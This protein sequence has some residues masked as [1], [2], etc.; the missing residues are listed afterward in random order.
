MKTLEQKKRA[1]FEKLRGKY[2]RSTKKRY[3]W[4]K[5]VGMEK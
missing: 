2:I 1:I 4:L 5:S 3:N